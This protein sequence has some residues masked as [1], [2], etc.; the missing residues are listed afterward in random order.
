VIGRWLDD[1]PGP[2]WW[3][4]VDQGG[5]Q[6]VEQATH[7]YDLARHLAGEA[8]VVGAG[9]TAVPRPPSDRA[10]DVVGSTSAVLRFD[11]GAVGSFVNTRVVAPPVIGLEL[12]APDLRITIRLMTEQDELR[13]EYACVEPA[14]ATVVTNTRDPYEVQSEVFLD[15]VEAGEPGRV[16]ATYRD[17]LATD[18]LTRSVVTA[19]GTA[20]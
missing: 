13:W 11:A 7:L 9:S 1:T 10:V 20:G 12:V 2:D 4:R 3:G 17:A 19:T 16:L 6:V 15:A 5:G 8:T 14:G 18:R